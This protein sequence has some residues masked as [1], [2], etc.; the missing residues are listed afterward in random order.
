MTEMGG[1]S[2]LVSAEE[3][4][5]HL[6]DPDWIVVDCRFDLTDPDAGRRAWRAGHIPGAFYADLDRDLA[7]PAGHDGAG[8]RH[9]LP[10]RDDLTELFASW[11]VNAH[12]RVVAYDDAGNAFAARLWWLLRDCGHPGAAVLDG[13]WPAWEA[14]GHPVSAERPESGQGSFE[15][16]PGALALVDAGIVAAGLAAGDLLLLDARVPDRFSG[17]TE[18]LDKC[19]GHVP[20]AV[21]TP[22]TNNLRADKCF[23]APAELQA[24]YRAVIGE[25]FMDQ[26]ACM[27]G[28]GV[29]ACH[30]LL[31]LELAGMPGA[32]LYAGSWSDWISDAGRPIATANGDEN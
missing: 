8:G 16:S 24:Y 23:R 5:A 29:T 22:L 27:C 7:A 13:G 10:G 18:P 1:A 19:A 2:P 15:A 21:N 28:S 30:T 11:G 4:A 20:G 17:R 12:S 32:A 9:P 6:D 3:L 26:V 14:A 25:K 31:A